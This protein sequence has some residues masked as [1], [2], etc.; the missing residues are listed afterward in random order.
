MIANTR[1]RRQ[2]GWWLAAAVAAAAILTPPGTA[3]SGE[4]AAAAA[5]SAARAD[6]LT[7]FTF[8]FGGG[9]GAGA[10]SLDMMRKFYEEVITPRF[11]TGT[12]L[13]EGEGQWRNPDTGKIVR[14]HSYT[15]AIECYPTPENKEK[16]S[17]I[18]REYVEKYRSLNASCFVKIIPGVTTELY[19]LSN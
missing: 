14:E 11:A 8:H 13:Q 10:V 6:N 16:I 2:A 9:V 15:L 12:T 4:K 5:V 1:G 18:A 17:F 3:Q 7:S 19:Y